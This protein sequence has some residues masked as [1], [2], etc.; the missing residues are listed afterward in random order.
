MQGSLGSVFATMGVLFIAKI[1]PVMTGLTVASIA[2][3]VRYR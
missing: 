3:A 2:K 1:L